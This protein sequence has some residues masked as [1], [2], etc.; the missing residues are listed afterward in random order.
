MTIYPALSLALIAAGDVLIRKAGIERT[1][2]S[3]LPGPVSLVRRRPV[4]AQCPFTGIRRAR[5]SS[6]ASCANRNWDPSVAMGGMCAT[7]GADTGR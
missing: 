3:P 5:T 1:A 4:P 6:A 7:L 2:T